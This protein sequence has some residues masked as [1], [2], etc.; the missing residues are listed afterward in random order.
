MNCEGFG[1]KRF[2]PNLKVLYRNSPGRTEEK[3]EKSLRIA[4]L[5]DEIS[6]KDLLNTKK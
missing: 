2:W 6:T 5:R 3:H 1:M 4:G